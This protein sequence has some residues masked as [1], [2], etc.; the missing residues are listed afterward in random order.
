MNLP[1]LISSFT[2]GLEPCVVLWFEE[3][4][5]SRTTPNSSE[6][7][8]RSLFPLELSGARRFGRVEPP[9]THVKLHHSPGSICCTMVRTGSEESNHP[10]LERNYPMILVSS[11]AEWFKEVQRKR[12]TLNSWQAS[13]QSWIY[14]LY[15]GSNR[16]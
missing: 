3:V 10:E 14:L 1:E 15:Y 13:P 8:L 5:K 6:I 16:F 4:R 7:T 2:E 12:T 9:R 11:G